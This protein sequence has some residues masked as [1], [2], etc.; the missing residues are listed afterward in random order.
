MVRIYLFCKLN[1]KV[2]NMIK[3]GQEPEEFYKIR[4]RK[5]SFIVILNDNDIKDIINLS[6]RG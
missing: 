3:S 1:G 4:N 6:E 5:D 2:T